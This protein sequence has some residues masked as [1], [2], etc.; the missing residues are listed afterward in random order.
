M[1]HKELGEYAQKYLQDFSKHSSI[2]ILDIGCGDAY[3]ISEQLKYL[4]LVAYKG[5]DLS[6]QATL[7]AEKHFASSCSSCSST[8]TL[9]AIIEDRPY[10]G[11]I[12][13]PRPDPIGTP[14]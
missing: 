3:Q 12:A 4:N 10:Q 14:A 11:M 8:K 7:F 5:Y 1:K 6:E 9:L 13:P 2:Q